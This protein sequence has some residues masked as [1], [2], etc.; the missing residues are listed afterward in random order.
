MDAAR[1]KALGRDPVPGEAPGGRD[2]RYEDDFIALQAEI[3]K[4][5]AVS[6]I[7]P[8]DWETVEALASR[9]LREQSKD[10]LVVAYLGAALLQLHG[11]EGLLAAIGL[12]LDTCALFWDQAFPPPRRMRARVNAFSWWREKTGDWLRRYTGDPLDQGLHTALDAAVSA[13]DKE[14]L[15]REPEF[16]SLAETRNLIR[17]MPVR[18]AAP[19]GAPGAAAQPA[20]GQPTAGQATAEQP[21]AEQSTAAQPTAGQ[22]QAENAVP[23]REEPRQAPADMAEAR[24]L[25][26]VAAADYAA[27]TQPGSLKDPLYWQAAGIAA[28]ARLERLPPSENGLTPLEAPEPAVKSGI[29]AQLGGENFLDAAHAAKDQIGTYLF[30]LDPHRLACQAL[31]KLGTDYLP[32]GLAVAA[33]ARL[34]ASFFPDVVNLHFADGTP[35]ADDDTRAWLAGGDAPPAAAPFAGPS[36]PVGEAARLAEGGDMPSAL[37]LLG[38]SARR[39]GT[40]SARLAAAAAQARLLCRFG[41]NGLALSLADAI[42]AEADKR[43]LDDWDPALAVDVLAAAREAY[44]ATGNEDGAKVRA[45]TARLMLLDPLAVPGL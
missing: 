36:L 23:A 31:A 29:M 42:L 13:L 25:L 15:E 35:F 32:A 40:G 44:A 14:L 12:W 9:I 1:Y 26:A 28:W 19:S 8:V 4:L 39:I 20:A 24:K 6:A 5:T 33:Q 27:F 7:S 11:S 16:P 34:F 41:Q 2:A 30:W 3:D 18:A 38:Q 17:A 22:P 37:N 43:G 10:L 21:T 45:I